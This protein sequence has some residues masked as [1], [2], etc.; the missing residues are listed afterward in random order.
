MIRD[1]FSRD[2]DRKIE[3]VIKVD[4]TDEA[5]LREE[6]EE[7]V[8]TKSIRKSYL[9]ILD[10]YAQRPNQPSDAVGVW[11][12]GFFGSG[13]SSFAKN[14]GLALAKR[15]VEETNARDL[16]NQRLN[17]TK[18]SALF[19]KI[20]ELVPDRRGDL[21]RVHGPGR[22]G[23]PDAHRDHLP[24]L[25]R[26][27][28]LLQGS[29]HCRARDQ[30]GGGRPPG[31]LPPRVRADVSGQG[32]GHP[33]EPPRVRPRRGEQGHARPRPGH[34]SGSGLVEAGRRQARRHL[35]GSARRA[36]QGAHGAPC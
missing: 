32:L 11:V 10:E 12:S 35:P 7:Y 1:L 2:I 16:L 20:E 5:I 33:E 26:A 28:R 3:E 34:L 9:E 13:K 14:L 36:V 6:L 17:D 18:A 30:P 27:P 24:E 15:P 22:H 8:V 29:R 19:K 4:Q 31:R 23:Q 21:R 25:P